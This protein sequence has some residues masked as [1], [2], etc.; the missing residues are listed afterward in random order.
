M[1][2]KG[3]VEAVLHSAGEILQILLVQGQ[4]GDDLLVQHLV[5]KAADGVVVHAVPH[6]VEA[7][8]VSAQHKAGVCAVQD[9]D[10][11][12]L[13]GGDVRHDH[14]V[15]AGLLERELVLQPGR[16]FD[17][18]HAEHFAHVQHL[19]MVAIG[20]F[21]SGQLLCIADAARN[22][23]VHQ[24]GAEGVGVVH[25]VDKALLQAPISSVA[26]AALL[27]LL[28]VVVDQLAGQD[29]QALVRSTVERLVALK[30]HAGQLCGEAVGGHLVKLAVALGVGNAGLGGVGDDDLQL[31][32][33]S[34]SQNIGPL[35][36]QVGAHA[37]ADAGDHPLGVHFLALLAAAQ[38]QGVQTLLRIDPV[39]HLGE[40]AN[41]LHQADLA[42]PVGLLVGNIKEII[43]EGPQEVALAELHDL[44][45]CIL[46][47]VAVVAGLLQDLVIQS[48]HD[49]SP[50]SGLFCFA[51]V[52]RARVVQ[53][54]SGSILCCCIQISQEDFTGFLS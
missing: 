44:D 1:V 35:A 8:Q 42:V 4:G 14:H 39:C 37:V 53:L 51:F 25:P 9:A 26:V 11:T 24:G 52:Q 28:A 46:Q 18:P 27:Q 49:E 17:D 31:G 30:Q 34:Q 2:D 13:V 21:Q 3:I 50:F 10:L 22:D 41:G 29:H 40:V 43:N 54:L 20:L 6:D 33:D 45:R 12:L 38:V 36:L 19:V 32:A 47:D 48:F 15:D 16:A 23:A 5:H 7:C